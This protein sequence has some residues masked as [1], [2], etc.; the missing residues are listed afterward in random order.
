MRPEA[1]IA[2][3]AG[4]LVEDVVVIEVGEVVLEVVAAVIVEE[5]EASQEVVPEVSFHI[6]TMAHASGNL[7]V[8]HWYFFHICF[9]L[10]RS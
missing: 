3:V 10:A 5:E 2:A 8:G 6:P 1:V 9:R 4:A 7:F